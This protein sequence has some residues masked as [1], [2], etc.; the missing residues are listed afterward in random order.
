MAFGRRE[1]AGPLC[2]NPGHDAR[3][4]TADWAVVACYLALVLCVGLY[5]SGRQASTREFFL[6]KRH[7]PWWAAALSIIASETSAVTYI[8]TPRMAYEGDWHS[9]S[10]SWA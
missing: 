2:Y 3:L 5:A 8:G 7:L 1:K 10:S 4:S 6:G 9:S